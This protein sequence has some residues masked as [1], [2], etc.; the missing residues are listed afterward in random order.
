MAIAPEVRQ[1]MVLPGAAGVAKRLEHP[2]GQLWPEIAVVAGV[3]PQH[4]GPGR[5]A[6]LPRGLDE[7]IGGAVLIGLA[8][9]MAAPSRRE[10]DDG[11][12]LLMVSARKRDCAPATARLSDD[13]RFGLGQALPDQIVDG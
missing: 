3:D 8:V 1:Q 10:G 12:D 6:K 7:L 9:D 5:L 2:L 13:D 11:A 4:R